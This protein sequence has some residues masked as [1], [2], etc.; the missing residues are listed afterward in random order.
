MNRM[1]IDEDKGAASEQLTLQDEKDSTERK[2]KRR[3]ALTT[4]SHF[5]RAVG[6]DCRSLPS[7][8]GRQR[9]QKM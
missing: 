3:V 7:E 4:V 1:W 2:G 8:E 5:S 9:T 6:A